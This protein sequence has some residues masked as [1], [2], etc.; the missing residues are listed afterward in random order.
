M[1]LDALTPDGTGERGG[2]AVTVPMTIAVLA[3]IAVLGLATDG[4]RAAHGAAQADAI[5]QEAARAAGQSLDA[6]A[7]SHGVPAVDPAAATA[8]ARE[9]LTAA[10][11][12]GTVSFV[13]ADV[14][15]VDVTLHRPTVLLGIIGRDDIVSHG[16][17]RARLV[18]TL[19]AAGPG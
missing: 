4:V 5:A 17:A 8:A 10:G 18:P 6:T 3:L 16:T 19:P 15:R 14:I 9:Y 13:G 12:Q 7:L 11:A 2:G 1:T